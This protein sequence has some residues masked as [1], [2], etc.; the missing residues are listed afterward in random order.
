[1]LKNAAYGAGFIA[2][3]FAVIKILGFIASIATTLVILAVVAMIL[4]GIFVIVRENLNAKTYGTVYNKKRSK[5][6]KK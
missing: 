4:V 3:V 5:K 2:G 6:S 1:M